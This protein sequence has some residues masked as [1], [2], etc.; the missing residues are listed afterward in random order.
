MFYACNLTMLLINMIVYDN[1][2]ES[3]LPAASLT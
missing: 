3:D 1:N 2:S